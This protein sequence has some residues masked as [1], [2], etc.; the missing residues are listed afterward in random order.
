MFHIL[1]VKEARVI[2]MQK[3]VTILNVE[4]DGTALSCKGSH[5]CSLPDK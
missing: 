4:V 3:Q 1:G 2:E 5:D